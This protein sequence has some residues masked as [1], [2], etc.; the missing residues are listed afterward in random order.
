MVTHADLLQNAS[1]VRAAL[2]RE[3][4]WFIHETPEANIVSIR[5]HGLLA[6]RDAPAPP[7][8]QTKFESARVPILYLH[9]LGAKLC[10][11]GAHVT[12]ELPLGA[13][14]PKLVSIA[15]SA[16]DLPGLVGLDWSYDWPRVLDEIQANYRMMLEEVALHIVNEY[17]S[18]AVYNNIQPT[19]LRV[20][21]RDSSPTNP[22]NWKTLTDAD[23][24]EI[25]RHN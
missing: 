24:A 10:P 3:Y 17:G 1:L 18:I 22:L 19:R 9:P 2:V 5:E 12:L 6:N 14:E 8:V 21:C 25:V 16:A 23:D 7:E 15:V 20:F 13:D 4:G 11:R